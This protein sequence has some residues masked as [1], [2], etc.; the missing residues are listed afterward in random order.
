[1]SHF[2]PPFRRIDPGQ[3]M[4]ERRMEEKLRKTDQYWLRSDSVKWIVFPWWNFTLNLMVGLNSSRTWRSSSY[5][6]VPMAW[7]LLNDQ[8]RWGLKGW[9]I[10]KI[11]QEKCD[12]GTWYYC[13]ASGYTWKCRLSFWQ[14][15]S[16]PPLDPQLTECPN[17]VMTPNLRLH[18]P[19]QFDWVHVR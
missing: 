13:R 18:Q 17:G 8:D 19:N 1:M 5:P 12:K 16:N 9:M 10:E 3:C 2:Q 11:A 15:D 7:P 14:W 4:G 6:L